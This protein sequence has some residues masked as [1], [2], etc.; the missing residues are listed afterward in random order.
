MEWLIYIL[1]D[2]ELPGYIMEWLSYT[3]SVPFNSIRFFL[4]ARHT[5]QCSY[6]I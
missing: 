1:Q 2:L 4:T 3:P 5:F 6:K